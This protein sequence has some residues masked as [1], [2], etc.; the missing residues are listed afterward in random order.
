MLLIT[1]IQQITH[2]IMQWRKLKINFFA[3]FKITFASFM[4]DKV[5]KTGVLQGPC[6]N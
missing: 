3:K 6:P 4:I 2:F 5:A 1:V